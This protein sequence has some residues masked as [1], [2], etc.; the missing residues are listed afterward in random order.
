MLKT[1][2]E[3]LICRKCSFYKYGNCKLEENKKVKPYRPAC[4]NFDSKGD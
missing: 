4:K 1:N 2:E 3:I